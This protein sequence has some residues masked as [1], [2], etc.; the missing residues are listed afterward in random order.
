VHIFVITRFVVHNPIQN[1]ITK[2]MVIT[3]GDF[4]I[5]PHK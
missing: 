3:V 4:N 1:A 5:L 2:G